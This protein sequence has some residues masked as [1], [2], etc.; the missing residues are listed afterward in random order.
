[1]V[2]DDAR[3][4]T[5]KDTAV[6]N[7]TLKDCLVASGIKMAPGSSNFILKILANKQGP[8]LWRLGSTPLEKTRFPREVFAQDPRAWLSRDT[9]SV[10]SALGFRLSVKCGVSSNIHGRR[11]LLSSP[12][13]AARQIIGGTGEFSLA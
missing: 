13:C 4:K 5:A 1:M 10:R 2:D 12:S 9:T 7:A 3:Q 6:Q 11:R 8:I